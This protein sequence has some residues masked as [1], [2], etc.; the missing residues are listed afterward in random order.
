MPK[1]YF[2]NVFP[3]GQEVDSNMSYDFLKQSVYSLMED[4][5]RNAS[6]SLD[7]DL[8]IG[9]TGIAYMYYHL[10]TSEGFKNDSPALLNK[11]VE[12]S[13]LMQH[14]SSEKS[15][16][17]FICGDA[18]VNAVYAAIF[19]KIGGDE[20]FVG[21]TGYLFGLLWLEKVF[22]RKII[23]DQDIIQL[24][25]TI[26]ESG[27]NYSKKN[28]SIFPLM[29]SYYNTE[30]LGAAHGLCTI[31]QVLISFPC[32][33]KNEQNAMQDIK[34]CIDILISLQTTSGNFPCA[35]DELGSRKR[36][37]KDELVH[38]CHGAPGV[39]YLLAKAYLVFKEPSYLE[40]CLKCGDLVWAK[41]LLKKGPG[42]CHGIAG[43]G[44]VFLLLYRLTGDTKHL[45]RAVQFGKFVFTDECIQ[46]SR[47]PD[48]LYSLYEGLAGTVCY[49]SD[50][51]QPDKASFP[52]LD[53][54]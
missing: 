54:F 44:Y 19:H 27:R 22:D 25:L 37:E 24:C 38:W 14:N 49:L 53:V 31:L 12:V 17:Q 16:H 39:V 23:A 36:P 51:I 30:Y 42:L 35:M 11:A 3:D 47:R 32:F 15:S 26:V 50:L 18:G 20:L 43:N 34:K 52:F 13:R 48:N 2:D 28:K 33:I 9:T 21:R 4:V 41:G 8:Y 1:R 6:L 29:Y 7:N 46:G 5:S 45:N 40:C 10:A